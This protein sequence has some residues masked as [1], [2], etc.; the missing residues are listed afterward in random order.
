MGEQ[1][2]RDF[3]ALF[4]SILRVRNILTAFDDF[5]GNEILIARHLQDYQSV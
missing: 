4:G 2:E 1:N 3:I 5:K